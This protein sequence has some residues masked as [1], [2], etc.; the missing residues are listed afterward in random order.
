MDCG[1]WSRLSR[2]CSFLYILLYIL[3]K[4]AVSDK[5]SVPIPVTIGLT[6]IPPEPVLGTTG[7][8]FPGASAETD[9]DSEYEQP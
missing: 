7:L 9:T 3:Y 1:E 5:V 6:K 2:K 4:V 8:A